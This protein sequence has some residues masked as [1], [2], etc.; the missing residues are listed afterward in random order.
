MLLELQH[1]E[2][3]QSRLN[4]EGRCALFFLRKEDY[5]KIHKPKDT[6]VIRD[7]T[8]HSHDSIFTPRI[9]AWFTV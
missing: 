2:T 3:S 1:I 9:Y 8:Y 5:E 7:N 6:V 4:R